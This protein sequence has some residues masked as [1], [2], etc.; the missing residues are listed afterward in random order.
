MIPP[1]MDPTGGLW[2]CHFWIGPFPRGFPKRGLA[3]IIGTLSFIQLHDLPSAPLS[4][5]AIPPTE[6]QAT[7]LVLEWL[8]FVPNPPRDHFWPKP[9][10]PSTAAEKWCG[11]SLTTLGFLR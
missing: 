10:V 8:I 11:D 1:K 5:R 2:S 6:L 7:S 4:E 3:R 9:A